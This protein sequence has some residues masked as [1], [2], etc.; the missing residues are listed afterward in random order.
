MRWKFTG[1]KNDNGMWYIHEEYKEGCITHEAI[2]PSGETL[3]ELLEDLQIMAKD[4]E[5]QIKEMR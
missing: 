2:M 5:R 1:I 4:I 3:E